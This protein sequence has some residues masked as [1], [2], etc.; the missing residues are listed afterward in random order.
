M[1]TTKVL[2][3][4]AGAAA[5]AIFAA[6][7]AA[8]GR[9]SYGESINAADAKRVASGAVAEAQRNNWPVAIAIVD[10]HG[11]LVYFEKMDDTQSA[12]VSIAIEKARTSAMFRRPSAA[13]ENGIAK[14]RI[15][16]LGLAPAMPI[17]GGL[18]IVRGGKVIGACGASGVTSEQDEQACAAGIKALQ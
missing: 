8:Q 1:Q 13:F 4:V 14:G 3:Q 2:L 11:F 17:Q 5:L 6:T 15:A 18:P 16:L 12:S 10:N 7:A 9:P